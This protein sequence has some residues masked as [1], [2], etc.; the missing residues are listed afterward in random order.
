MQTKA[1]TWKGGGES[2]SN[3]RKSQKITVKK[4]RRPVN[5]LNCLLFGGGKKEGPPE[6]RVTGR[7]KGGGGKGGRVFFLKIRGAEWGDS[8]RRR[9]A[10]KRTCFPL[11]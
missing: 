5:V 1:V 9:P 4:K 10:R 7:V 2:L 3:I 11:T 8:K 6:K